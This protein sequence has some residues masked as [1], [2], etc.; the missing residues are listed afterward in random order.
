MLPCIPDTSN[1]PR[2]PRCFAWAVAYAVPVLVVVSPACPPDPGS[3][4]L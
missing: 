1:L 4:L 2:G 3:L